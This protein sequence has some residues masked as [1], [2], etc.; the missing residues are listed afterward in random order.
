M[1]TLDRE[2]TRAFGIDAV[3]E[4]HDHQALGRAEAGRERDAGGELLEP[5]L[6][7]TL[8]GP[9]IHGPRA[10]PLQGLLR[11]SRV[12]YELK[13]RHRLLLLSGEPT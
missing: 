13:L 11:H 2:H 1:V 9:A 6:Q 8:G 5:P 7:Y 12:R 10:D 3:H 4:V